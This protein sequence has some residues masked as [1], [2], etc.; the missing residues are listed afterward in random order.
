[1]GGFE[2]LLGLQLAARRCR[3]QEIEEEDGGRM[4]LRFSFRVVAEEAVDRWLLTAALHSFE[5]DTGLRLPA[6][7]FRNACRS[8]DAARAIA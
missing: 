6:R 1:M 3:S 5:D 2:M 8:S 4:E 7:Q